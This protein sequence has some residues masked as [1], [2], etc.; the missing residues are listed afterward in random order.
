MLL[1]LLIIS[2]LCIG[3]AFGWFRGNDARRELDE[4]EKLDIYCAGWRDSIYNIVGEY[5]DRLYFRERA[6]DGYK[7]FQSSFKKVEPH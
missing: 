7:E 1:V 4:K 2:Q 6:V 3:Y 5:D